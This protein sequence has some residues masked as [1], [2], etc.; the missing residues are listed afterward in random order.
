VKLTNSQD[1]LSE[2]QLLNPLGYFD[3]FSLHVLEKKQNF[4]IFRGSRV[5]MLLS[6]NFGSFQKWAWNCFC[7][8]SSS[9]RVKLLVLS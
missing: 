1:L 8:L 4:R 5:K 6:K 2:R 3:L 7:T 9:C